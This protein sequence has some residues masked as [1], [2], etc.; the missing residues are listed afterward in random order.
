MSDELIECPQD[1]GN[2]YLRRVCAEIFRG[3]GLRC[4]CRNCPHFEMQP[5]IQEV[6]N[7]DADRID[8]LP[9]SS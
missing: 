1:P 5:P 6:N 3:G 4:W 8:G 9:G 2:Y 7:V